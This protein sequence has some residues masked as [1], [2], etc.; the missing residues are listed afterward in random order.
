MFRFRKK[1]TRCRDLPGAAGHDGSRSVD[2]V[3]S[4]RDAGLLARVTAPADGGVA[5]A[6]FLLLATMVTLL[7]S[8]TAGQVFEG[9]SYLAFAWYPELRR[10]LAGTLR[11][12]VMPGFVAFAAVIVIAAFYGPASWHDSMSAL[13]GWRR[14]LL[15][16]LALAVFDD[17]AAKRMVLTV[18]AVTCVAA[19][20][21][22]FYVVAAGLPML[23]GF[24]VVFGTY[25][26]QASV[27]SL[28]I[29]GCVA[30]LLCPQAFAGHRLLGDR[31]IVAA[32]VV[33]LAADIVFILPGRSGYVDLIVMAVVLVTLLAPGSWRVKATAGLGVLVL[34]GVVLVASPHVRDRVGLA[35][36]DI[37]MIDQ[38]AGGGGGSLQQRSVMWRTTMRMIQDHPILGVGTGGFQDGYRPYIPDVS[39]QHFETGDP[40][41]QFLKVLGE[42]GIVGLAAFLFFI[43]RV[44]TCPAATPYRQLAIAALIAWCATSL[45]NSHFSTFIES[46]LLFFWLGAMLATQTSV[47]DS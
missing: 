6:R 35:I 33:L 3:E 47:K 36:T 40:H 24:G 20:L 46:R 38:G 32:V 26:T 29:A 17:A 2:A 30:A 15:L 13:I 18:M 42:Q 34:C 10:R 44:L 12:P 22:A 23:T 37:R 5:F 25:V 39:W 41:N 4:K 45:A 1:G 16:P 27:F 9:A 8:V 28:V 14:L 21:V 7:L 31:R 19:T 43:F 11:H